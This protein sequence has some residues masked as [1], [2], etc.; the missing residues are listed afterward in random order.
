MRRLVV[1]NRAFLWRVEHRHQDNG[2]RTLCTEVLR[3]FAEGNKSA[4]L[5]LVFPEQDGW[6]VGYPRAGVV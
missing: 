5:R 1:S 6:Q 2:G 3:I 4:L